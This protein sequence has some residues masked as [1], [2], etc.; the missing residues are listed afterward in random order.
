MLLLQRPSQRSESNYVKF[1]KQG[2]KRLD[3]LHVLFDK[4][5]VNR[6]IATSAANIFSDDSS[7]VDA[8]EIPKYHD[9]DVVKL[10]ALKKIKAGKE[11]QGVLYYY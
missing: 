7:E 6:T 3:D 9:D 11:T 5:H 2:S 10:V 1:R 8:V 4:T